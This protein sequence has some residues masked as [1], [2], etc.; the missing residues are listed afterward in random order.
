MTRTCPTCGTTLDADALFCSKCGTA[1]PTEPGVPERT[2]PTGAF[3]VSRVRQALASRYRIEGVLGEGGMATVYLAED[4][5][6]KR[7]VAIKVMRPELAATLG[8]GRFTREVEIAAKL[9][10]PNILPV[11]DSGELGGILYY[12]MPVVEGESLP[13]R[14]KR[15]KQLPVA[16]ALRLAREVA[17]ALA[18]AHKR[19][20]V[21]RDIKPANIL[22][23]DGHALVAD[24]GIARAME[25]G[26]EALTQTGLAIGTP[27]YMSPEQASGALDID[28][29]TD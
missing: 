17:E 3:E 15:E 4:L 12:V 13:A 25:Q 1:T 7:Q 16:E 19:G 5:K 20:F 9:S 14:L 28:G 24:F 18:Y 27:H 6:H 22:L 26:G 23:S 8:A 29:R 21:H 10:H 11:Y 2:A